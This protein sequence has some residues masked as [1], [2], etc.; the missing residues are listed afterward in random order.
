[1][2]ADNG[3]VLRKHPNGGFS[4]MMYFASD[5]NSDTTPTEQSES[6]PT[7]EAALKEFAE[8]QDWSDADRRGSGYPRYYCEYGLQIHLE[9]FEDETQPAKECRHCG[10]RVRQNGGVGWV[11]SNTGSSYCGLEASPK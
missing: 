9:C 1:M 2:S 3:Y 10:N 5:E 11:H 8:G 4:L 7:M 6:F